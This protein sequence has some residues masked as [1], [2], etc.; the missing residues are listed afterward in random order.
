MPGADV[1]ERWGAQPALTGLTL[2][3]T[4]EA[5]HMACLRCRGRLS[6]SGREP[7]RLICSSCGQHYFAVMQLIEVGSE[8]RSLELTDVGEG[9]GS[10]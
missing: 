4:K 6:P 5:G 7:Y 3:N 10:G 1:H 2:K 9:Q 8:G